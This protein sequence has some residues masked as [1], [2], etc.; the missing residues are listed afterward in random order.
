ME[1]RV[2]RQSSIFC[3]D[4]CGCSIEV[5]LMLEFEGLLEQEFLPNPA[6]SC[7][8]AILFLIEDFKAFM[9]GSEFSKLT[10]Q[11]WA[12]VCG[13]YLGAAEPGDMM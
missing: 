10:F 5:I 1:R 6:V 12:I 7:A 2:H 13:D 8:F 4:S 3:N 11:Y 9:Y